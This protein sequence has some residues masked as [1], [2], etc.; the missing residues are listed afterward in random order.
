MSC[1]FDSLAPAVGIDSSLLRQT[2]AEYLKTDPKL[3]DDITAKDIIS[4]TESKSLH[5]YADSISRPHVWGGGLEIKA[6]C[7][8][9][10]MNVIVHVLYTNKKFAVYCSGCA[11]KQVNISYTGDHF[12]PLYIELI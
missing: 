7:E 12:E 8:L 5:E 2:I 11:N 6:F 10:R 3:L 9:F 1:L 4:W